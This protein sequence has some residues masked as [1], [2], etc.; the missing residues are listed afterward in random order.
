MDSSVPFRRP[1]VRKSETKEE[2]I[3]KSSFLNPY[4]TNAEDLIAWGITKLG[5]EYEDGEGGL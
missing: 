3:E 5:G 2:R 1:Y 4:I